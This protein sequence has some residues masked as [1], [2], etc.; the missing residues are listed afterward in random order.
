MTA[1]P[2]AIALEDAVLAAA[3]EVLG[4][5]PLQ[6]AALTRAIADRSRRY[7]SERERLAQPADRTA[8][9][10]ARAAFFTVADAPKLAIPIAELVARG[11]IPPRRPL[12]VTDIG[13]GCGALSLGLVASLAN[14]ELGGAMF[15]FTLIDHD[16]AALRIAAAALRRLA[17][18]QRTEIAIT[19]RVADVTQTSLPAADLV[20]AGTVFNELPAAQR[21]PLARAALASLADDGAL[22]VL[23]PA[24]RETSRALHSLRDQLLAGGTHVFAPCTRQLA[25]C[26]MLA[27]D[28]DWCHEAR[29][30]AL[31]P[32][33]H[34]L[35]RLTHLRDDG[36]KFSYLTLRKQPL[37]LSD[38]PNA[39]RVVS[40]PRAPKGKVELDGCSDAGLVPLRLLRRH[41]SDANR[42]F[43]RAARG[44]VVVTDATEITADTPVERLTFG[45]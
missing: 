30:A 12:R 7:T 31:P 15:D 17:A 45:R 40:E 41:R 20:L 5:A 42:T 39:W 28:G 4:D 27:N 3:R 21:L 16:V 24:L 22:I 37:R 9:L 2:V 6:T 34:E 14:D 10:A 32:H 43:E 25:P 8:D 33:T 35:A 26:P 11:A 13:A 23:E 1:S 19:T 38:H 36:L 44:D 18:S 29:P